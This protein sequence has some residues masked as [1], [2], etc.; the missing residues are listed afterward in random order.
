MK[1]IL[2][3]MGKRG[4]KCRADGQALG[5]PFLLAVTDSI[6]WL[7]YGPYS[8]ELCTWN[9]LSL[10]HLPP[11]P[12]PRVL[13][14]PL[15]LPIFLALLC[16]FSHTKSI[17]CIMSTGSRGGGGWTFHLLS[18]G[19]THGS[20]SSQPQ[21]RLSSYPLPLPPSAPGFGPACPP[22]PH[23]RSITDTRLRQSSYH[24]I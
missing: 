8:P 14:L 24:L 23:H 22:A 15:S 6:G 5:D 1:N 21:T 10:V 9:L 4:G 20:C 7:D 16:S 11:S 12:N 17:F 13:L 18:E 2:L 3:S 19:V